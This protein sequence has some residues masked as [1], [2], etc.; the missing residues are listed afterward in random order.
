MKACCLLCSF[1]MKTQAASVA[2]ANGIQPVEPTVTVTSAAERAVDAAQRIV[3]E[4]LELMRLETQDALGN[5]AQRAGIMMAAGLIA[6]LGWCGV[7]VGLALVLTTYM[8]LA[9]SAA[10]VGG[11]H[12]LLGIMLGAATTAAS[13]GRR[14]P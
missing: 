13:G 6:I 1:M 4:R 5:G 8:S 2:D 11:G 10:L 9:A 7:A 14:T 3:I 12:V